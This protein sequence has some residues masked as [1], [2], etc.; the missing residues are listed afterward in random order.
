M[1]NEYNN[2]FLFIDPDPRRRLYVVVI[3]RAHNADIPL[4]HII[5]W[6]EPY[7]ENEFQKWYY[8]RYYKLNGDEF[9]PCKGREEMER[10]IRTLEE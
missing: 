1:E 7:C 3:N 8:K 5:D 6:A 4:R 10:F 2:P 9:R